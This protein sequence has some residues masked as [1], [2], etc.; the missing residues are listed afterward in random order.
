MPIS[1]NYIVGLIAEHQAEITRLQHISAMHPALFARVIARHQRDIE[2]LQQCL[3]YTKED[4][5]AYHP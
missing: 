3:I 2:E 5:T 4:D 1:H